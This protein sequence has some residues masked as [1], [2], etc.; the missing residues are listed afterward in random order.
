MGVLF[1]LLLISYTA[2]QMGDVLF[3]MQQNLF[4]ASS[5]RERKVQV[6][7]GERQGL[8]FLLV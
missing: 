7:R 8:R 6:L 2:W 3:T 1:P 5:S 4:A